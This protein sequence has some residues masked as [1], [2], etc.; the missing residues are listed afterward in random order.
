MVKWPLYDDDDD[1][2]YYYFFLL[3]LLLLSFIIIPMKHMVIVFHP[4]NTAYPAIHISPAFF[5]RLRPPI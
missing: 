4:K 5:G 1:D 2:D 3:L